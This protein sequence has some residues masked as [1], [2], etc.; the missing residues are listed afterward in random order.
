M[1]GCVRDDR[2]PGSI[3]PSH[4]QDGRSYRAG[5]RHQRLGQHHSTE[6][7]LCASPGEPRMPEGWRCHEEGPC[8]GHDADRRLRDAS[9]RD[10]HPDSRSPAV[11]CDGWHHLPGPNTGCDWPRRR[12]LA[13]DAY[14][15]RCGPLADRLQWHGGA[16]G[17]QRHDV[18]GE[19][20][21]G[22]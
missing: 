18:G 8:L 6:A 19:Q 22:R 4:G 3:G 9:H 20:H 2:Q 12:A 16:A 10:C 1:L 11:R 14:G 5:R 13:L 7:R 15:E 17:L 21:H